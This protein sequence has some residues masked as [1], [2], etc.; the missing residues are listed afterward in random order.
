MLGYTDAATAFIAW[1]EK[2]AREQKQ[3]ERLQVLYALDGNHDAAEEELD[4]LAG[5]RGSRPMRIGNAAAEQLQLDIYGELTDAV[6]LADKYGVPASIDTW[7]GVA[8][9]LDWVCQNWDQPDEGIWEVH[10]PQDDGRLIPSLQGVGNYLDRKDSSKGYVPGNVWWVHKDIN[11]S[12]QNSR[13]STS[14]SYAL[15]SRA[16]LVPRPQSHKIDRLLFDRPHH[17]RGAAVHHEVDWRSSITGDPGMEARVSL[18][19]FE[20]IANTFVIAAYDPMSITC[21]EVPITRS[22]SFSVSRIRA[23]FIVR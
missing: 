23:L 2:R 20:R 6:Y 9:A 13:S 19:R 21:P 15:K 11:A 12:K 8:R 22:T 7:H 14:F 5:Y 1:V 4:H 17:L 18:L 10:R 3:G 16:F